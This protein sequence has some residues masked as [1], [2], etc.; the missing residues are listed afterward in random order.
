MAAR[1]LGVLH[2]LLILALLVVSGLF[3]ALLDRQGE[4][5]LS[6][7]LLL[8]AFDVSWR[9]TP[10][11]P[12]TPIVP[13]DRRAGRDDWIL[14]RIREPD[15]RVAI[16]GNPPTLGRVSGSVAPGEP[17]MVYFE[18]SGLL[19]LV[20]S[21]IE[22]TNPAHRFGTRVMRRVL[23][24][25][26]TFQNNLGALTTL[27]ATALALT[28]ALCLIG[29][30]R[31]SVL[32][33][34]ASEVATTLR[35]QIHRQMYRLGQS[36]MPTEGVGPVI[37]V[38]TREVNDVRDGI[39]TEL[40]KGYRLPVLAVGLILFLLLVD[41]LLTTVLTALGGLVL[42]TS[43]AMN[44][45]ARLISDAAMRDAA[46]QLCL[47]HEDLGLLRTV[48]VYGMESVENERFDEHLE[49]HRVA[50][51]RRI[52]SESP[53]NPTIALLYG[54]AVILA[55]GLLGYSVMVTHRL[56][57]AS[58][59]VLF[60]ALLGLM[61]P[62]LGWLAMR[63]AIRQANR[64]AGAVFEFMERKPELQQPVGAQ[65]LSPLHDRITFENVTLES[66][67][68]RVLLEGVSIELPAGSRTAVMSLDEDAKHAIV[69][70]IPRL[71]D[72][73]VGRVRI[74]GHD[75]RDVTLESIRAQ[76]ATV[77]QADLVFTDS[78]LMNIGLGDESYELPRIIEAAKVAHAHHFI[79]DLPHGYDTIIGPLGHY[80]TPDQQ[81]R[82]ALAR[83]FLHDPSI[84]IIEEP[85]IALEEDTKHMIDDTIA[86]L[87]ENRT[88]I[89]LPHR[90]STI[91]S[92]DQII[93]LHNGRLDALGKPRQL[94][95]E[96]KLFRHLQY[97]EFNQFATGEIEAGQMNA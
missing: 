57:P 49:R 55:V 75:L 22:S 6:E 77:L 85:T 13:A 14:A 67:S 82:I 42:I 32:A 88:L 39:F 10:V 46:L 87:A 73:K 40:D 63:K 54:V 52:K 3:V 30:Y 56:S 79:Q 29:K 50:D 19:P 20:V 71:I 11:S 66:R 95:N 28:L 1:I 68:G 33:D 27:L 70:L 43:L 60:A 61:H 90:L 69:C 84:V 78:V 17:Q 34:A 4:C 65:F 25:L 24:N 21:N 74:D 80:L 18:D 26:P 48:R 15:I 7:D 83:A 89:I 72:P 12:G 58:S 38:L 37:N 31:R 47:L 62:T 8:R 41:P 9:R 2:S 51:A 44:R 93:L 23:R 36:A 81:Y 86:R 59:L 53:L 92:C 45:D 96:N 64:S 35:R 16:L 97:V 76:V 94:Q 91:R 5:R